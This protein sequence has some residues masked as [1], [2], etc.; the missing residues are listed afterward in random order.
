M[1]QPI[2]TPPL[3]GKVRTVS[4]VALGVFSAALGASMTAPSDWSKWVL[5]RPGV[6]ASELPW[7]PIGAGLA[8]IGLSRKSRTPMG[9]WLGLAGV[10]LAMRPLWQVEATILRNEAAMREGLGMDYAAEIPPASLEHATQSRLGFQQLSARERRLL[11]GRVHLTPDVL[12]HTIDAQELRADLYEP[13]YEPTG[14]WPHPAIISIHG[15]SWRGGDKGGL[16]A[17]HARWLANQGYVVLDVQYRLSPAALWPAHLDDV[18]T[19]IRW[20]RTHAERYHVDPECIGLVG[21]SAGGHLALMAAFTPNDPNFP[22][23]SGL[24]TRDDVQSVAAIYPPTDLPYLQ[25]TV[26]ADLDY[27]LGSSIREQPDLYVQASPIYAAKADAPPVLL[28]HGGSD[29]L[30]PAAHSERLHKRLQELGVTSVYLNYPWGR[31][32]FDFS[33]R[34]LGGHMLQYDMDRFLAWTLRRTRTQSE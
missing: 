32:G 12:F 25:S 22:A 5:S 16:F 29:N 21:R 33:L 3:K 27:W 14:G 30:V 1:T 9:G 10:G 2:Q 23:P 6:A 28:A 18:K 34:G 20:L 26:G 8:A 13:T 11:N 7:L 4:S 31:H 19:A 17:P 24:S 15:G